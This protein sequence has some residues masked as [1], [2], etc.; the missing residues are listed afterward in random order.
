M[1]KAYLYNYIILKVYNFE[2]DPQSD[3][4]QLLQLVWDYSNC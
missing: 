1:T 2:I 3:F 4:L